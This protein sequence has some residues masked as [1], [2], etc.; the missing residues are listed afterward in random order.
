V[1]SRLLILLFLMGI[2]LAGC[3][4]LQQDVREIRDYIRKLRGR[5]P[6]PPPPAPPPAADMPAA[7]AAGLD[8]DGNCIGKEGTG[9]AENVQVSVAGG[10]VRSLDARIDIPGRGSCRFQLA[11][12]RQ[13][14]RAPFVELL[15]RSNAACALRLW[16]QGDRVTLAATDCPEACA[17]GAF[18]FLWPVQF[19]SPGGGCY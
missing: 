19:L 2:G 7:A 11:G 9:Y 10:Q 15:S 12:F 6:A 4:D 1:L 14:Q 13:T 18:D 5:D 3:A 16:Q 8:L 17:R